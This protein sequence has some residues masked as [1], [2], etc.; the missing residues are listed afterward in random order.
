MYANKK[1][2]KI[3]NAVQKKIWQK[4]KNQPALKL[5]ELRTGERLNLKNF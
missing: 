5:E 4:F 3:K 2:D 1:K